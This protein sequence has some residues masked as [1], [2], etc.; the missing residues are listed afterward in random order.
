MCSEFR[1]WM[2]RRHWFGDFWMIS[3]RIAIGNVKTQQNDR[4][5]HGNNPPGHPDH[6]TASP[7]SPRN[8]TGRNPKIAG[9]SRNGTT[10]RPP[11]THALARLLEPA[12]RGEGAEDRSG[13]VGD[14]L[15]RPWPSY[16]VPSPS[17]DRLYTVVH[18]V[19]APT[20]FVHKN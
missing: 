1:K 4:E 9:F 2:R 20:I 10:F 19:Q 17:P 18:T 8:S 13:E 5:S 16:D 3:P 15:R 12:G 6:R 7:S 11:H 14:A